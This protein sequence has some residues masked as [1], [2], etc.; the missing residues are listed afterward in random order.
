LVVLLGG[1][2]ASAFALARLSLNLHRATVERFAAMLE[3][4]LRRQ[5]ETVVRLAGSVDALREDLRRAIRALE[6]TS[7]GERWRS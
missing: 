7:V 5:E 1:L 4:S 3:A 6:T 2:V